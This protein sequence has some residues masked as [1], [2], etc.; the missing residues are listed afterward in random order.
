[1]HGSERGQHSLQ[2]KEYTDDILTMLLT[3]FP[4]KRNGWLSNTANTSPSPHR[5]GEVST[6]VSIA[7]ILPVWR[8]IDHLL[9]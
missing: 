6:V 3:I 4:H 1:M 5:G 2:N 7:S 8:G 9:L